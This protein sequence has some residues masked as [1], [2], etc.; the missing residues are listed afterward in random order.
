MQIKSLMSHTYGTSDLLSTCCHPN[1]ETISIRFP[2]F[3][4]A[5]FTGY[6]FLPITQEMRHQVL[7]HLPVRSRFLTNPFTRQRIHRDST[8]PD[9]LCY[10]F[11]GYLLLLMEF[12]CLQYTRIHRVCQGVLQN[13][14]QFHHSAQFQQFT[15]N[16]NPQ[17]RKRFCISMLLIRICLDNAANE[18]DFVRRS[19]MFR[20]SSLFSVFCA[21]CF[22]TLTVQQVPA[23]SEAALPVHRRNCP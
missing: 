22:C 17:I 8:T 12:N 5:V 10:R 18:S 13:F 3:R 14:R 19:C 20:F 16:Q 1:S 7:G 11:A 21:G 23:W 15:S 2:L 9:S 6:I 4:Y